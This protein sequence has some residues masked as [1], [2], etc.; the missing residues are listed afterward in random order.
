MSVGFILSV[1]VTVATSFV[2]PEAGHFP[3]RF[4]DTKAKPRLQQRAMDQWPGP[5]QMLDLWR[6]GAL[7]RD[8][9]VAVLLG[10]SASHDPVLLPIYREAVTS[11]DPRLRMAAVYGYRDLL[12]DGL[13]NVSTGVDIEAG[14]RVALEMDVVAETLRARPLSEFWLQALLTAEGGVMPGWTGVSMR[15]PPG[16]CVGALEKV[17]DIEDFGLLATAWRSAEQM[18]TKMALVRLLEATTL[19][20]FMVQPQGDRTGW[21]KRDMEEALAATDAFV[22]LWLDQ[23]CTTDPDRV[24][25]Y[26]LSRM[27]VRGVR[28]TDPH[29]W[30][31][32]VALLDRGEPAWRMIAAKRLYALGG[33]WA[34]LSV[35]QAGSPSQVQR[36]DMLRRDYGLI[37][38][39][40][41][42]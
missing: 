36:L 19:Q 25:G 28:P 24:V 3:S 12:G 6:A 15:R 38:A 13:P 34:E 30:D 33:R 9:K 42:K 8:S 17:I 39:R 1:A 27:G 16:V 18:T 2:S 35:F 26:S 10:C 40:H 31:L 11:S 21:G 14:R 41:T 32:W 22:T 37:P 29:G 23:Q 20:S 7:D 5:S 4:F